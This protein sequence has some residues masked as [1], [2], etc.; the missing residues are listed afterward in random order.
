[1]SS[2]NS[3][4]AIFKSHGWEDDVNLALQKSRFDIKKLSINGGDHHTEEDVVGYRKIRLAD[5]QMWTFSLPPMVEKWT[6]GS[7]AIEYEG[8]MK[9]IGEAE[10]ADEERLLEL[11]FAIFLLAQNYRLSPRDFEQLLVFPRHS[12][13]SINW[14]HPCID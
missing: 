10:N 9:A 8:L 5:G 1:M 3:T 2:K 13:E 12:V 4:D 7:S 11:S 6:D 14:Q